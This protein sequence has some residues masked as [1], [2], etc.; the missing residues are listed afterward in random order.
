[1]IGDGQCMGQCKWISTAMMSATSNIYTNYL[2]YEVISF[3]PV[4]NLQKI[5]LTRREDVSL[6]VMITI[7]NVSKEKKTTA[8]Q[9]RQ[10][11]DKIHVAKAK[12]VACNHGTDVPGFGRPLHRHPE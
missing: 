11:K 7:Q 10:N 4:L 8:S 9:V 2:R 6:F 5:W 3:S 12:R 1:M